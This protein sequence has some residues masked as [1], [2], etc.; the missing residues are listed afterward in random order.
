MNRNTENGT[1]WLRRQHKNALAFVAGITFV[2]ALSAIGIKIQS[3][4]PTP[5][6]GNAKKIFVTALLGISFGY[7]LGKTTTKEQQRTVWFIVG[8]L[9]SFVGFALINEKLS[10]YSA[11][12]VLLVITIF[13]LFYT[14]IIDESKEFEWWLTVAKYGSAFGLIGIAFLQYGV[15]LMIP[16]SKW[17]A[18]RVSDLSSF[19]RASSSTVLAILLIML[20]VITIVLVSLMSFLAR[21]EKKDKK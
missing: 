21:L 12:L 10:E 6:F 13:L 7:Y 17:L 1:S 9:S 19:Y 14:S 18:E 16:F 20:V 3:T 2:G 4:A 15:P 11:V 8:V 5:E